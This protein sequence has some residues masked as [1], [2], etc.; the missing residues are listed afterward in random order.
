MSTLHRPR[1]L[2]GLKSQV[3]SPKLQSINHMI[4][5]QLKSHDLDLLRLGFSFQVSAQPRNTLNPSFN[6]GQAVYSHKSLALLQPKSSTT[7][8]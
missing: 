1:I 4:R 6:M 7:T 2:L 5:L 3:V 8:K